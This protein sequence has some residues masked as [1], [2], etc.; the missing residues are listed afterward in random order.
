MKKNHIIAIIIIVIAIG[1]MITSLADASTYADF[2]TAEKSAG[3]EFHVIGKLDKAKE[4][5]YDP[6]KDPNL[7]TFYL[8]DTNSVE[9]KVIL[10]KSKPQDFEK[11][12]K[13]VLIGK[14]QNGEF[15]ANEVLMK[16]PSK[17]NDN[18]TANITLKQND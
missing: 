18:K 13:I 17:Y 15:H 8:I 1:A 6:I 12:E 4:M 2:A 3:T 14:A 9:R 7:F 10:Y 5:V 11:S 16:C